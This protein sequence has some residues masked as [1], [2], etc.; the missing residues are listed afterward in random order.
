[1]HVQ[2]TNSRWSVCD[3][4]PDVCVRCAPTNASV[5]YC[6]CTH[7]DT[8]H[9]KVDDGIEGLRLPTSESTCGSLKSNVTRALSSPVTRECAAGKMNMWQVLVVVR[10]VEEPRCTRCTRVWLGTKVGV[11]TTVEKHM[12]TKAGRSC[13]EGGVACKHAW[14]H[15]WG[16][17]SLCNRLL[18]HT[19]GTSERVAGN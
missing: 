11:F 10:L 4:N 13:G 18:A 14:T 16:A 7:P 19:R 6:F 12:A 9:N 15:T 1:M 5:C 17:R 2:I 3:S 8:T